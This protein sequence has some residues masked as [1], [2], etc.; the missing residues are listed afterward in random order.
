MAGKNTLFTR[1]DVPPATKRREDEKYLTPRAIVKE[2]DKYIIGQVEAKKAVAIAL[3]NRW[4]RQHAD[5][6]FRDEIIP[7]NI[8]LI[9]P[10]GVGKTEMARRM[11]R[12]TQAP[13][14]KV[15]ASKY[16]EVGY[17]GRDVDSMIRDLTDIGVNMVKKERLE[18]IR[19]MVE[20][21]AEDALLD[22]LLPDASE[23]KTARKKSV[24][25]ETTRDKLRKQLQSGRLENRMVELTTQTDTMAMMQVFSPFGMEEMGMNLQE[26]LGGTLPKKKKRKRVSVAE[27]RHYLIQEESQKRIDMEEVIQEA[28]RRVQETGI[29][30][31]D[32]I[33]K[34]VAMP[35]EAHGPDV[36]QQGVQRD[37]LPIVEGSAVNTKYGVVRTDHILFIA[38]GAFHV[39]KPSDLIPEL[40]GRFPIRVNLHGLNQQDFERILVEPKNSLIRQ[41]TELFRTEDVAIEFTAKAVKALSDYATEMNQRS[42]NIGARRL[43]T[44]M[45]V[46]LEDWLYEIPESGIRQ[47]TITETMVHDKLQKILNHEDLSKYIL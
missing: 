46:L 18:A 47:I 36:S 25:Y 12:I 24:S 41:Y 10:T 17:V 37:L 32:E 21:A 15:E 23:G 1:T 30:F 20:A 16:T 31:I 14:I 4:R 45:S 35:G 28:L 38:S 19:P 3:R 5:P 33:D 13:F 40:Q 2:L 8:I 6:A 34:I 42:E 22:L 7:N 27:A 26:M 11:A 43:Q 39:S 44:V 9:G 29:V